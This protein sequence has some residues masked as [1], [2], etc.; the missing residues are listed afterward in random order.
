MGNDQ[1]F[2]KGQKETP[3]SVIQHKIVCFQWTCVE[4]EVKPAVAQSVA[5]T[6]PE[7]APFFF[8]LE[9]VPLFSTHQAKKIHIFAG[10]LI[11]AKKRAKYSA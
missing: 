1:P 8:F 2:R 4:W 3:G 9:L 5:N 7:L 6:S 11:P 10:V